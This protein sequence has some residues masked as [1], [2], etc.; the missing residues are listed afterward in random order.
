ML[1]FPDQAH[2]ELQTLY[3]RLD[4]EME[5]FR[6]GC[7]ASGRCCHFAATGHSL[8]VTG[9]EA[10]EMNRAGR[11]PDQALAAA[12]TCPFLDGQL[13]GIREHRALGCRIYYCD[14]T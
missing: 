5:P 6:R 7:Q 12:D 8:F 10:A 14:R 3:R 4:V 1:E 2:T 13:C 9:L 11:V